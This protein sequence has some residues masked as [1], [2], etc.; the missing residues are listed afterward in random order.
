M[1]NV[2]LIQHLES[3]LERC[4]QEVAGESGSIS[5]QR[6]EPVLLPVGVFPHNL[7]L[8][9]LRYLPRFL[10]DSLI[11]SDPWLFLP[12][13]RMYW[14]WTKVCIDTGDLLNSLPGD[15]AL[16]DSPQMISDLR[17][18]LK[19]SLVEDRMFRNQR[20]HRDVVSPWDIVAATRYLAFGVLEGVA[21]RRC[22]QI[23]NEGTWI[24][25]DLTFEKSEYDT[26]YSGILRLWRDQ[27]TKENG[28]TQVALEELDN[29]DRSRPS[30]PTYR[31]SLERK[32]PEI[33]DKDDI[34]GF[35]DILRHARNHTLHA[36]GSLH[37]YR[38]VATTIA[39][40]ALFDLVR[41]DEYPDVQETTTRQVARYLKMY[42]RR[43]TGESS[44]QLVHLGPI[45]YY[46]HTGA[47]MT[48]DDA[49][50]WLENNQI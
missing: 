39:C 38:T 25:E 7:S 11:C 32:N 27:N 23:S 9:M 30:L 17:S 6:R 40:M 41:E 12:D 26:G 47:E 19:L 1:E 33:L 48:F 18:L 21:R 49:G 43:L 34:D 4:V 50:E 10:I 44:Q 29:L 42:E 37:G 35:F 46:P 31:N 3:N 45:A 36:E 16:S 28:A 24:E 5:L 8:E 15:H 14:A 20:P 2:E 13:I 22:E